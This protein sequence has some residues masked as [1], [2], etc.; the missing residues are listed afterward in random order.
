MQK[1]ALVATRIEAKT[2][3]FLRNLAAEQDRPLAYIIRK[4]L[5][6]FV[7]RQQN[8]KEAEAA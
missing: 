4:A 8:A 7:E 2:R 3:D 6:Q 1:T 5:E